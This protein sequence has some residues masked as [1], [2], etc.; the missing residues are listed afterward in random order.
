MTDT[1]WRTRAEA[2][3]ANVAELTVQVE[4]M[5]GV[6]RLLLDKLDEHEKVVVAEGAASER[7]RLLS[8]A[9]DEAWHA[10][11]TY[12]WNNCPADGPHEAGCYDTRGLLLAAPAPDAVQEEK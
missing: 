1:D 4:E 7:K 10:L 3:E 11:T 2:A 9:C 8:N 6:E 12:C 5:A